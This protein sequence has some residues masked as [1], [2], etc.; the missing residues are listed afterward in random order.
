MLHKTVL[1]FEINRLNTKYLQTHRVSIQTL[2]ILEHEIA[3]LTEEAAYRQYDA[4]AV[5]CG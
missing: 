1:H 5:P 2:G 3:K 4:E